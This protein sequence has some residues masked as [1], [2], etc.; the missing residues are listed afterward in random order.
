MKRIN[1]LLAALA[2]MVA[3]ASCEKPGP[4]GPDTPEV[5]VTFPALVENYEVKPG[6]TL[7]LTFTPAMDWTVSVPS[8]N[9]QWFWIADGTFKVDK[10]SRKASAEAVTVKIG[11]SETEEFDTNRSCDVTLAIGD[12]S[13]VIAKYMRPAKE[14]TL[15]VYMAELDETGGYKLAEDGESYIYGTTEAASVALAWS[16][17]DADFRAPLRVESNGEWTVTYPEWLTVN[18]PEKTAGV[19]EIILTG[20]SLEDVSGKI[21]FKAGDKVIKEIDVTLPSCQGVDVRTAVYEDEEF[22]FADE[23]GYLWTEEAVDEF[24]LIWLG[25][26]FRIPVNVSSR[27]EW[28]ISLPE[29]LSAELPEKTAGEVSFT[30]LGVPSKYPLEDATDKIVF[31]YE[32]TVIREVEVT[33]P[34]C[35]DIMSYSLGMALAALDFN[36]AGEVMTSTGY[37]DVDVTAAL[38]GTSEVSVAAFEKVGGKYVTDKTP[39]WMNITVSNFNTADGASVLQERE[40]KI[41]VTENTSDEREAVLLF[42]PHSLKG[43]AATFIADDMTAVK[44]E[45]QKYAVAVSQLSNKFTITM[46]SSEEAMATAGATF[47]EASA[48]KKAELAAAFGSTDNV[49]VLTYDNIYALDEARMMMSREFA[50]VKVFDEAKADQSAVA[51]FW[52]AFNYDA[53][54]KNSGVVEMYFN[55][56]PAAVVLPSE[57]STGYVVF[58]D[59]SGLVLAIIECVSPYVDESITPPSE[60]VPEVDEFEDISSNFTNKSASLKAGAELRELVAGPTYEAMKEETYQG[61]KVWY[62][63]LPSLN[64]PIGIKLEKACKYYQMPYLSSGEYPV[65]VNGEDYG[66][67][68]G[69]LSKAIRTADIEMVFQ[70]ESQTYQTVVRFHEDSSKTFPFLVLFISVKE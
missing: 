15:A 70:P 33:I 1:I 58:Y 67:T 41:S 62:L 39:E 66:A 40:V 51:D 59:E 13:K 19:A 46:T 63:T 68:R 32:D 69:Q 61:A 29:W 22:K 30:L 60:D 36:A 21:A 8:E 24:S 26:D 2:A 44:E 12:Q 57:A 50:A 5:T 23:G 25:S 27:C 34:G 43:K 53:E 20:A 31:K 3:F 48:E 9:L 28:T 49:Y 14:R 37:A 17:S 55:S 4:D 45:Y 11:V 47:V 6:E 65:S 38:F 56:D 16:A 42:V 64:T 54:T 18:V 10:L 7:S 52:L 35:K